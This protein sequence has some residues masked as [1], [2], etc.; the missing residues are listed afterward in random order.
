MAFKPIRESEQRVNSEAFAKI[1][2]G[3]TLDELKQMLGEPDEDMVCGS[4][5]IELFRGYYW[6]NAKG[7]AIHVLIDPRGSVCSKY[8][9]EGVRTPRSLWNNLPVGLRSAGRTNSPK[10]MP[11]RDDGEGKP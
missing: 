2:D 6:C 7:Y 9:S 3:M 1:Q 4:M 8:E 10:D 5:G 11:Q